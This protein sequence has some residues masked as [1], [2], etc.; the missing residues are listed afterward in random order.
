[1]R[2]TVLAFGTLRT[3]VLV[4]F[5]VVAALLT[6]GTLLVVR[7]RVQIHVDDQ[8]AQGLQ[9]SVITFERFQRQRNATLSS[10][11]A[12]LANQPLLKALMTTR[13]G[14]TI[15]DASSEFWN[16]VGSELFVLVDRSGALVALHT[17]RAGFGLDQ[18]KV[19]LAASLESGRTEDWWFGGD[20][21]FQIFFQPIYFGA[22][23][24]GV[25]LG[26]VGVGFRIDEQ[27]AR[28]IADVASG[29]VAFHYGNSLVVTTVPPDHVVALGEHV[30]E[31]QDGLPTSV[32]LELGTERF[33]ATS[34][35]VSPETSPGVRLTVLK[36]YD[37]A[38]AFLSSLNRWILALGI[39]AMLGGGAVIYTVSAT[40]AKPLANLVDGVHALE[41]GDFDYPLDLGGHDE[42]SKLTTAFD[43]MRRTV[44]EAQRR[45]VD[46][47]RLAVIGRMASSISHD[48]RHPLT[49]IL[50]YAEFLGNGDLTAEKRRDSYEEIRIAVSRMTDQIRS[51]LAFSRKGEGLQLAE[52]RL[53]EPIAQA[54]QTVRVLPEFS[55]VVVTWKCD[56]S[57][58]GWLDAGKVERVV[59]NLL[60]N[61]CEAVSPTNGAVH[62]TC[63]CGVNDVEIRVSDNGP[64]IPSSIRDNL[65][66]PF[67]SAGKEKGIGLGLTAVQMIV[68]EHG[69]E[70]GL[71]R[72]GP[73]GTVFRV[74]LP[75]KS[76]SQ[77][78]TE[79]A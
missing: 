7:Y 4:S 47:E 65:F 33:L 67:T 66:D 78:P 56:P 58:R 25:P 59:L 77:P 68:Q 49:A 73:D 53:D 21:L 43:R 40:I 2:P 51:L 14:A 79:T 57:C 76:P 54:V 22:A 55:G 64:G 35:D 48:L 11:A 31:L 30:L 46:S 69:G 44:L 6:W 34:V 41:K 9:N 72:T 20:E 8:I 74:S 52:T 19:S 70:V 15:Q 13:D 17:A 23:A 27:G 1:M 36:S 12:L 10:S 62:V 18:A 28:D 45:L 3:K 71:E 61:A 26:L 50:A 75:A 38:T 32:D 37:Q 42:V 63:Q 60:F 16:L 29:E 39:L 24:E 5:I